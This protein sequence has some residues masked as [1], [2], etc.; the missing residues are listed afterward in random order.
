MRKVTIACL[1][2]SLAACSDWVE[3]NY[4]TLADAQRGE[5]VD[6]GWIPPF[7]PNKARNIHAAHNLDTN[8]QILT[9]SLPRTAMQPMVASITPKTKITGRAAQRVFHKGGWGNAEASNAEAYLLCTDSYSGALAVNPSTERVVYISPVESARED[10]P[11]HL[12]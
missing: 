11:G 8:S 1:L 7:V 10:C 3:E 4:A 6:R 9:F 5:A 12:R 2:V